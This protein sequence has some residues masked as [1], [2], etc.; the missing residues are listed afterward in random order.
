[1]VDII[2]RCDLAQFQEK[3]GNDTH[4]IINALNPC[5]LGHPLYT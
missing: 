5:L 3:F 4:P 2:Q 1:M